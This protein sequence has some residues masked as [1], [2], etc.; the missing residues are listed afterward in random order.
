MQTIKLKNKTIQVPI[1]QGGMGVGISLGNLAGHVAQCGGL[2]VISSAHTGY[3]L[4]DFWDNALPDNLMQLKNE[5][6][7]AKDIAKGNGMVGVNIMV[8][9]RHY[10][11]MVK[12]AI[13]GGADAIIS[14]AGIPLEL[15]GFVGDADIAIAPIVSSGKAARV[16]CQAWKKHHDRLPDFIVVEG[17]KAGGHLGFTYQELIENKAQS[18]EDIFKDVQEVVKKVEEKYQVTIPIFVAGGIYTGYDI[19]KFTNM[20]AAG[21]QMATRFIATHECDASLAFKERYL[22]VKPEDIVLMKSTVGMPG[23]ALRSPFIERRER[24]EVDHINRCVVCL[25]PC[26]PKVVDYC[27]TKALTEA[28]KGNWEE[29][30]FF[31]G[32]N[33]YRMDKI[34]HVKDIIDEVMREYQDNEQ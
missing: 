9:L 10:D 14:G 1:I 31:C 16:I 29:G 13:E 19:R 6:H 11:K 32:S 12:A 26:N 8:A 25:R 3:R 7:K 15:P 33:G 27:I 24:E 17:S 34:V 18:L 30:L 23:R 5:I 4:D 21:V 22:N 28:A 2:G 20:G